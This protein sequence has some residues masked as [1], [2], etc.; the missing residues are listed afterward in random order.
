MARKKKIL[1]LRES[2]KVII[3]LIIVNKSIKETE[4]L[5][6]FF[7][8][9]VRS[10]FISLMNAKTC[11]FTSGCSHEWKYCFWYSFLY[12][13]LC[14]IFSIYLC[15]RAEHNTHCKSTDLSL[16]QLIRPRNTKFC[17]YGFPSAPT[18]N[19]TTKTSVLRQN[20]SMLDWVFIYNMLWLSSYKTFD[21]INII[22]GLP[23]NEN[24]N[25]PWNRRHR[26]YLF[27]IF[28]YL[29]IYFIFYL[30]FFIYLFIYFFFCCCC[31]C[32]KIEFDFTHEH[33]NLYF[34]SWR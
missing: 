5:I 21:E 25:L 12:L 10:N 27:F 30:F 17:V 20:S 32:C 19:S 4:H 34:H 13:F 6:F 7:S 2:R 26:G 3:S 14:W 33:Q 31:C 28:I 22:S 11:I 29:F 16:I 24:E 23:S 15:A 9:H 1:F 8:V 18:S